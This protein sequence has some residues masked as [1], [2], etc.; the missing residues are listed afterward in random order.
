MQM[1]LTLTLA[2]KANWIMFQEVRITDHGTT[3]MIGETMK[4]QCLNIEAGEAMGDMS[5]EVE[6]GA[7]IKP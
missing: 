7:D 4:K 6:G 3:A 1:M 2:K 5:A